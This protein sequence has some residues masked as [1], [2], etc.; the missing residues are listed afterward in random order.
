[1][2]KG[3]RHRRIQSCMF[4]SSM[5]PPHAHH[6]RR[7]DRPLTG[8]YQKYYRHQGYVRWGLF[9]ETLDHCDV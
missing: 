2:L 4:R 6:C 1:M 3:Q 7:S 5:W 9:Q 8:F